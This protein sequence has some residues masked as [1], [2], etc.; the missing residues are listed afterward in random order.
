MMDNKPNINW[1]PGHMAKA[2]RAMQEDMKRID[3]VIEIVDARIVRSSRNPDIDKLAG[4]KSRLILLNKADLSQ[5]SENSRWIRYFSEQN[6]G[7]VA[8]D[9]RTRSQMKNVIA[10]AQEACKEKLERDKK[11]GILNRP[12]KAMVVG[13]PNVGKSTFINSFSNKTVAKTGNK[14]GVTKGNQW[15]RIDKNLDL[16]DTPGL[17]WPKFEDPIVGMHL[18][19]IGS[20]NDNIIDKENL[21]VHFIEEIRE[22][23]PDVFSKRYEVTCE[24]KQ[25]H[26]IMEAIAVKKSCLVKGGDPDM[27]RVANMILD[28]YRAGRL[29]R[30]SIEVAQ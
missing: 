15:I 4:Q 9:A 26:E 21:C 23:F 7:V 25:P 1:Y 30:I 2:R 14:P 13:I 18:A 28:D 3:L 12:I 29:G 19:Y 5:D 8:L 20:I 16:L 27:K 17:L 24:G 10:A 11:R 22:R 6:I